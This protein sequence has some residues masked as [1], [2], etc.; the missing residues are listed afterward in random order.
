[1]LQAHK[2]RQSDN[3]QV[4]FNI[5]KEVAYWARKYNIEPQQLKS[6]FEQ[7]GYSISRTILLMQ[8]QGAQ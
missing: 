1:M 8:Q 3:I 6:I 5:S 2:E 4:N 7:T